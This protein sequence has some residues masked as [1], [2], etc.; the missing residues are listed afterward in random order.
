MN[1]SQSIASYLRLH[2]KVCFKIPS[3]VFY[4]I[5][6]LLVLS[7]FYFNIK[8]TYKYFTY[9]NVN[10]VVIRVEENNSKL[11]RSISKY[12]VNSVDFINTPNSW[13][14]LSVPQVNETVSIIYPKSD[15]S[16]G[17]LVNIINYWFLGLFLLL[18]GIF[19]VIF[20]FIFNLI[21]KYYIHPILNI[22]LNSLSNK[23][24]NVTNS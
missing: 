24:S 19:F 14:Q 15:I 2:F 13:T 9:E 16:K 22:L 12:T 23:E 3:Y 20:T 18:M 11:F 4:P 6:C 21:A 7:S 1:F 8:N 17:E 5:G 10:G